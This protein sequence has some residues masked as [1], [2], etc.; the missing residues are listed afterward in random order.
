MADSAV[1]SMFDLPPVCRGY[2]NPSSRKMQGL[3]V[4]WL[5]FCAAPQVFDI[6]TVLAL[7]FGGHCA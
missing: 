2:R 5:F 7:A 3:V 1:A 4:R 6:V